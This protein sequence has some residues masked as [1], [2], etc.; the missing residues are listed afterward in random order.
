MSEEKY[1]L[2]VSEMLD[3]SYKL[4]ENNKDTWAPMEPEYARSFI[5]YMIEEVG[6]SIAIIKKK[7][8]AEIM[9][10]SDV[11]EH[12]VEEMGD[13]IMYFMDVLNRFHISPQEFSKI[14]VEKFQTNMKRNYEEQYKNIK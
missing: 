8:E 13:V 11:R 4:W 3:M 7:G 5:L 14:Y 1:D 2:K 10:N 6:E 9:N 12:F